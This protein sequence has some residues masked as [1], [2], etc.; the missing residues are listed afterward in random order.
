MKNAAPPEPSITTVSPAAKRRSLNRRA[1][2]ST[3]WR[4]RPAKSG[5]FSTCSTGP[6]AAGAGLPLPSRRTGRGDGPALEQIERA[7]GDGP[8]DVAALAVDLLALARE[9]AQLLELV[10]VEAELLD[11]LGRH[12]FLDRPA[13]GEGSGSRSACVPACARAPDRRGR[14]GRCRGSPAPAPPPRPAPSAASITRSSAPVTGFCVNITPADV[15]IEQRLDDDA[16]ARAG[17]EP[18]PLAVR[19]RR[20]GVRRPPDLPQRRRH[21]VHRRH[22]EQREVL[23]REAR[24]GA[25]LVDRGRA[26]RERHRQATAPPS[27][28]ARSSSRRRWPPPRRPGPTSAT[29]GG[30]G[31]PVAERVAQPDRLRPEDRGVAR[32]VER[33]DVVLHRCVIRAASL[34]RRCRRPARAIPSAMRSVASRVPTTPGIPYSRETIA[35]CE[36]SPP[37]SVTIAPSSGSRMLNASVVARRSPARRPA[38]SGRTRTGRR[39]SRAGPS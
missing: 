1:I 33:D 35:E 19:D 12:L 20:V 32:L 5:T 37:L 13:V 39:S 27:S 18:D 23:A 10:V 29:P 8:L 31:R 25:V 6:G 22:V 21:V 14:A 26:H 9:L 3:S 28:P 15:G 16:D 17:E 30:T 36:S 24:V 7:V 4:S 11:A 2:C 34:R 38:G